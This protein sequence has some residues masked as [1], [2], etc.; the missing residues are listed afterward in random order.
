MMFRLLVFVFL[1]TVTY[2]KVEASPR[3]PHADYVCGVNG[4]KHFR[5]SCYYISADVRNIDDAMEDCRLLGGALVTIDSPLENYWIAEKLNDLPKVDN[6]FFWTSGFTAADKNRD[7]TYYWVWGNY[8]EVS[9]TNWAIGEPNDKGYVCLAVNRW[10]G[11]WS[12]ENC[13]EKFNVVCEKY[14]N[15]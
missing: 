6:R 2:Y 12:D 13:H 11:K 15:R 3:H 14:L 9:Y 5:Q 4:W 10:N 8:K 1:I 7:T